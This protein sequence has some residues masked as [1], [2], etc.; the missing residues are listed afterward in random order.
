[1]FRLFVIVAA[2][3]A[4]SQRRPPDHPTERALFRDL[5][6][7]VTIANATGWGVDRIELENM[8]ETTLDSTCRVHPLAR[9]ALKTW[10]DDQI[11]QHG[12][13]VEDAW[14]ERGKEMKKVGDL[15]VLTRVRMLLVRAEASAHECPFWIEPEDTYRGRQISLRRF[16]LSIGGGGKGIVIQQGKDVDVS[17]GG[18]GRLLFGRMLATGD[19]VYVGLEVGGSAAFPKDDLGQRGTLQIAADLVAPIVYR[20]TFLNSY[21]ELE[22]GWI[23]RTT[24]RD[25][26]HYDHGVHVGMAFGARALR[27]RFVFPGAAFGISYERV[28]GVTGDDDLTMFKVGARVALDLDL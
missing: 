12:G 24:E 4:C 25:W 16:Q 22:A 23:G 2:L 14:R 19:G 27:T 17:A 1:M 13:P 8:L 5:E 11:I 10:L 18:A 28:W 9:R 21:L 26:N 3:A 7:Q 15:L 20:R 6:R